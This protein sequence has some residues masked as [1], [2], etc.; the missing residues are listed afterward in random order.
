[1]SQSLHPWPRKY[2]SDI[3]LD[4]SFLLLLHHVFAAIVCTGCCRVVFVWTRRAVSINSD[5]TIEGTLRGYDQFMNIVLDN[6][7]EQKPSGEP[8]KIGMSL[9]RGNSIVSLEVLPEGT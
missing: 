9:I 3:V 6:C 4:V 5:R 8:R 1:M 7:L 2:R